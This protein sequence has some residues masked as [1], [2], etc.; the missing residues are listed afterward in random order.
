MLAQAFVLE[1][2]GG[3]KPEV[4]APERSLRQTAP[5]S[6]DPGIAARQPTEHGS[7]AM[8]GTRDRANRFDAENAAA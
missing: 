1:R 3:I 5:Q 7:K 2:G 4:C 8:P 6:A